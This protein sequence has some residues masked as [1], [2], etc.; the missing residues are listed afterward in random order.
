[1]GV[2]G[3]DKYIYI[4]DEVEGLIIIARPWIDFKIK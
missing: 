3:D 2:Y 1:M 4:A